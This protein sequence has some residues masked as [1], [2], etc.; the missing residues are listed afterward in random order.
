MGRKPLGL[1]A[2]PLGPC[3]PPDG[4]RQWVR[5]R[6]RVRGQNREQN[7]AHL[8]WPPRSVGRSALM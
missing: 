2:L 4:E 6:V 1:D 7:E 5:V 3:M 8:S